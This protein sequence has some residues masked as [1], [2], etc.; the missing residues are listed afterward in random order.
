MLLKNPGISTLKICRETTVPGNRRNKK[1]KLDL[2]KMLRLCIQ[3]KV[4]DL[5]ASLEELLEETE[6]L[7]PEEETYEQPEYETQEEDNDDFESWEEP[8][9][10]DSDET[11]EEDTED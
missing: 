1:W 5:K 9:S 3:E 2:L 11:E 4:Q 7:E 6:P 10:Q 8:E